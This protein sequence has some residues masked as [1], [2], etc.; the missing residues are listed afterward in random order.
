MQASE[1]LATQHLLQGVTDGWHG[2]Q[3]REVV[4]GPCRASG[5]AALPAAG[6]GRARGAR[7]LRR[8]VRVAGIAGAAALGKLRETRAQGV[9]DERLPLDVSPRLPEGW[10]V[11]R[12]AG[13]NGVRALSGWTRVEDAPSLNLEAS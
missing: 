11:P 2:E 8:L 12:S 5:R 9:A 3:L 1:S 10:D 4:V 7:A 6:V 13:G